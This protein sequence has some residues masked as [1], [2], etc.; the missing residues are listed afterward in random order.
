MMIG[1]S[2]SISIRQMRI[3][4]GSM[5]MFMKETCGWRRVKLEAHLMGTGTIAHLHHNL[6]IINSYIPSYQGHPNRLHKGSRMESNMGSHKE[7]QKGSNMGSLMEF[8]MVAH[9]W[10]VKRFYRGSF[11]GP[12]MVAHKESLNGSNMG[13]RMGSLKGSNMVAIKES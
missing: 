5:M 2:S 8:N 10:S 7:S 9:K 6:I 12:N 1:I 11:E 13:S 4:A 3:Q